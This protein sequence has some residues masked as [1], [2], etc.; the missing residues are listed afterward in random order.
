[1]RPLRSDAPLHTNTCERN[2]AASLF[3]HLLLSPKRDSDNQRYQES[4]IPTAL[5]LIP[6]FGRLMPAF[7]A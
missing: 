5:M 1:M 2:F 7:D 4:P 3:V 6:M